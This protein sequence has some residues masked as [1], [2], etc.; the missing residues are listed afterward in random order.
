MYVF[1]SRVDDFK[2]HFPGLAAPPIL[3]SM[4]RIVVLVKELHKS[5]FK[6]T[7]P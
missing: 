4:V 5:L 3:A 1:V 7:I 2:H 6:S